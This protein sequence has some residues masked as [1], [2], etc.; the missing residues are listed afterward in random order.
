MEHFNSQILFDNIEFL[1][2]SESRKIGEVE[3]AAGVSAGYISRT[4]KDGGSKPGIDFIMN[5]AKV[6]HVSIDTLLKVEIASLTPTEKYL[7][8][9]LT[10]LENDTAHDLLTWEMENAKILNNLEPDMNGNTDHPLFE[11]RTISIEGETG[12]PGEI[13]AVV[14]QSHT[15]GNNTAIHGNC[16][17]LR[18]KN[19]SHLY[20]MN[21]SKG[22]YQLDD[23]DAFA[24]ELWMTIPGKRPQFLC[25]NFKNQKLGDTIDTL[26]TVVAED[27]K[28][29]KVKSDVK[30]IIDSF[31]KNDNEND[32]PTGF[33]EEI[34]F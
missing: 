18:L 2:K 26:Y 17:N 8:A 33:D 14:F 9:F 7:L 31:M 3:S 11:Y 4:S 12:Y 29:P 34:P 25:S 30:Y 16:Y 15:F 23:K 32:P 28:N 22:T 24:K 20:I 1:I 6:L 27:T 19:E 10:K 5:I 21:I 13:K